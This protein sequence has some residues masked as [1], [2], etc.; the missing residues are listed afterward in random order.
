MLNFDDYQKEAYRTA[1]Y[2]RSIALPY[3]VMG[4]AGETGEVSENIKK[5][6]RDDA[7]V[8]T[9]PR[10]Q[11]IIAELGDVLWY[12]AA[13]C[14][15]IDVPMSTVA[16]GNLNKLHSREERRVLHGDGDNR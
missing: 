11:K 2:L 4:L 13:L 10:R 8:L 9:E 3:C 14:T 1:V 7:G 12:I 16:Q 15:E 6:Y 5:L